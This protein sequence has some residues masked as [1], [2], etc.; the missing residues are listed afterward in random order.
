MTAFFPHPHKNWL[1]E[2]IVVEITQ[3]LKIELPIVWRNRAVSQPMEH[4]GP[5]T[6]RVS[7]VVQGPCQQLGT[8]WCCFKKQNANW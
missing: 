3:G 1:G 6:A 4:T 5:R 8:C 2:M 7:L